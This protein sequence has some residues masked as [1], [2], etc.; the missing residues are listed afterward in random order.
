MR[1]AARSYAPTGCP[2]DA[3]TQGG[4]AESPPAAASSVGASSA[5]GKASLSVALTF[6]QVRVL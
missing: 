2:S 1:M 6:S 5:R 4:A 3:C